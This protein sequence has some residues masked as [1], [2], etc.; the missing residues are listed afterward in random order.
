MCFTMWQPT[1]LYSYTLLT[2]GF[3][4]GSVLILTLF[5]DFE[6]VQFECFASVLAACTSKTTAKSCTS[7]HCQYPGTR[8]TSSVLLS[9]SL[10][11]LHHRTELPSMWQW[12]TEHTEGTCLDEVYFSAIIICTFT[13]MFSH[14]LSI[15]HW[16]CYMKLSHSYQHVEQYVFPTMCY[17]NTVRQHTLSNTA[18]LSSTLLLHRSNSEA[19]QNTTMSVTTHMQLFNMCMWNFLGI[20]TT[21]G[22]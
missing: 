1:N 17:E 9:W 12:T 22:K 5:L 19:T 16:A 14:F 10:V 6:T 7:T 15:Q 3:H 8:S 21:A 13:S 4:A 20:I 18:S 2:Y 11:L